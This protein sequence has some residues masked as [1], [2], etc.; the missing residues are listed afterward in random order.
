MFRWRAWVSPRAKAFLRTGPRKFR[1]ALGLM[2][3]EAAFAMRDELMTS[4]AQRMIVRNPGFVR[5]HM[6]VKRAKIWSGEP[7]AEVGSTYGGTKKRFEGWAAQQFGTKASRW[8]VP[9]LMARR[10]AKRRQML[11]RARLTSGRNIPDAT[12][13][14]GRSNPRAVIV[15][16]RML[17]RRG[18]KRPF[19]IHE[20]EHPRFRGGLYEM[21]GRRDKRGGRTELRL[22]QSFE[23]SKAQP[24]RVD[25]VSPAWR[26]WRASD[27]GRGAFMRA[28]NKVNLWDAMRPKRR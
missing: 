3:N 23:S 11:S 2:V 10:G 20:G 16:M 4:I 19:I 18:D 28:M 25:W 5:K 8:R 14:V 17:D 7:T 22:L 26:A 15:M 9:T 24:R 27:S 1:G 21:R 6:W 13:I 12:K